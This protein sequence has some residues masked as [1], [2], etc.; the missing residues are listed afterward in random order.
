MPGATRRGEPHGKADED[1]FLRG[2]WSCT[3]A[4][5]LIAFLLFAPFLFN[6]TAAFAASISITMTASDAGGANPGTTVAPLN[7]YVHV[8][9]TVTGTTSTAVTWSVAGAGSVDTNGG[10]TAPATMP[11]STTVKVIAT[12]VSNPAITGSYTLTLVNPVPAIS[13]I[14]PDPLI[15]GETDS[16]AV[17]GSNFVTGTTVLVGGVAVPTTYQSPILVTAQIAIGVAQTGSLSLTASNPAPGGGASAAFIAPISTVSI[18]MSASDAGGVNP[19]TTV[20]PLNGYVH[21]TATVT[22]TANKTVT[23]SVV[24]A[25]SVDT[26]G[27]YTA[28]ATMPAS[29]TV[30]VIAT[31]V[32]NPAIT[33]SYTLTLIN[34][35]PAI[36]QIVPNPL[37]TGETDSVAVGG[38]N[39]VAGTTILVGG[40]AV[41]TTYQSP[42]LVTAQ[43]AIGV[44]QTG[45]LSLTA[46]NPAPGG[47]VSAAFI[48]PISTVSIAMSASDAGGV[49]PGT[50][51]APLNGYVHVVATVTG[52]ANKTVTWSV[53]GGG[54]VDTAGDYNAPA[55]MPAST[56]VK[57]VATL[58]S[59]PAITGSY[60][61]TLINPVPAI[62]QIVP[63]PLITG[64]TDSVAVGGSNFVA[65]TT[66][67]VGG[68]AVPTTYQSPILVTAQ[69]AVGITQTGSLSL[70]ASNPTP[71][72]G[73]SA[74]FI[75]PISKVGI[76]MS[77]SYQ[78]GVDPGTTI[79]PLNG[80]VHVVATVTGTA[81]KAV[82]WSVIGAGSV[83][84]AGGYTAPSTMPANTTVKVVATLI[85][86]PAMSASYTLT[87][88]NPVPA[89]S[90]IVPNPLIPGLTNSVA[91]GGSNFVAGTIVSVGGVAVPTTYQSPILVT[92][93]IP[94]SL[95][96]TAP[97]SLTA[98]NAA[99]GGG[100]STAFLAPIQALSFQ[101]T[102]YDEDGT[103]TN[104]GRLGLPIQFVAQVEGG[105]NP[106]PVLTEIW[107]VQGAGTI[108]SSGVYLAP[109]IMPSNPKVTVTVALQVKSSVTASY[110]FSLLNTIPVV[111]GASP[112]QVP[113]GT[114]TSI[115]V[116]GEGFVSG[117]TILVNGT[118]ATTTYVSP[119][120]VNLTVSPSANATSL[121]LSAQNPAPG[122]GTGGAFLLPVKA[123]ST[124]A[125]EVTLN[126]G[127]TIPQNFLGLSQDWGVAQYFM[128]TS[129]TSINYIYRQ[130]LRNL[131][132]NQQYAFNIRIH[133]DE[134]TTLPA[135]G[136][137]DAF[138][139]LNAALGVQF[140][141]GVNLEADSP[142]LAID[143]AQFFLDSMPAGSIDAIE[144]GNEPDAYATDGQRPTTYTFADYYQ[145]FATWGSGILPLSG[146]VK[147][148]GPSWAVLGSLKNNFAN[149]EQLEGAN[150]SIA[151][152]HYYAFDQGGTQPIPLTLDVLLTP[153]ASTAGAAIVGPS[154]A[155]AHANGQVFRIG[156]M[157]SIG[158][159][160]LEGASDAFSSALWAIDTMF[161][162]ANVGVD[163]VNWSGTSDSVY[164]PFNFN[165]TWN[166]QGDTFT[167]TNVTPLYYGMLFFQEATVN[168]SRLLPVSVQ[169]GPNV[170]VWATEDAQGTVRVAIL[171]KDES[172]SGNVAITVPGYGTAQAEQLEAP[173]YL[174]K[175][176]VTFNG[177]TFDGSVDGNLVGTPTPLQVTPS[178]N[179]YTVPV[180]PTSAILLVIS[181]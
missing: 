116:L 92:A 113:S 78:N 166:G 178:S 72:G 40:V 108:S 80:Y 44:S 42:I 150:V 10:Y 91:V 65:G 62:S 126:P 133:G 173:S 41:P 154:V 164:S 168:G 74:A 25:G 132:Q 109:T 122:G 60:T 63:N 174:S 3:W 131:M 147:L 75:A 59:N 84:T 39:F 46:S 114:S 117:T 163:G 172:F 88:V 142:K 100:V 17:G 37:I 20:A 119:T 15:T 26:N 180:E 170:K 137:V 67:L 49:N 36:A 64:E 13:Q 177:Q 51:V 12:L 110:T 69:I 148:M 160:G 130:L 169:S 97:L 21:V 176:G 54:T 81:N 143:Q 48:A 31:L 47:G 35:V 55:T 118:P 95:T 79:A 127:I 101:L 98:S 138:S 9:A 140:D 155:L 14:V 50:T 171:N 61:L 161:E 107:S 159:G 71:G 7:G 6:E 82:T 104:T 149:F 156:E 57:V 58:V 34:P 5:K 19:G 1:A 18:A 125:A 139:Q 106:P 151:S 76:V 45:S 94:V 175:S 89:I 56:T 85:S 2:R 90:Q 11:A 33:G 73:V 22:G 4:W 157:N 112:A 43:I 77:A 83:D 120:S 86:I 145:D 153:S 135:D 136:S 28:P 162:F 93:Q 129:Q 158:N 134:N 124:L 165:A 23:W 29:T 167:L 8:Y 27:G 128:G 105:G 111:N 141:M 115:T 66:I 53:I 152:H 32:S 96:Q 181:Q 16:V 30:K 102:A 179:V 99:P 103:N 123:G 52:T 87:L 24:G 68:V 121:S 146:P 70:T 144:I 38:S